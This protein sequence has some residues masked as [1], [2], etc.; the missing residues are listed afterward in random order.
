MGGGLEL[1][2]PV[3]PGRSM[4]T[5]ANHQR[6]SPKSTE[7]GTDFYCPPGT[8]VLAPADGVI[9]GYGESV[10]PA[11]GRWVGIDF[12]NGM[13]FRGMHFQ[14][15]E[16][17]SGRVKRGDLIA[18]SGSSGYGSEFF[19]ASH[20]NDAAMIARTGGPH[21]HATLWPTHTKR[22]GYQADGTPFTVDIMNYIGGPQ[23]GGNTTPT[24]EKDDEIMKLIGNATDGYKFVDELG[25]D[26]WAGFAF[27]QGGYTFGD[28]LAAAKILAEQVD[29]TGAPVELVRHMANA[30][31]DQKRSQI[32]TDVVTSLRPLFAEI[33]QAVAGISPERFAELIED[34]LSTVV[35]PPAEI[36][37]ED[38]AEI[39]RLT[40][41]LE[42][43]RLAGTD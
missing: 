3:G 2:L 43:S 42:A 22:Y 28:N 33:A 9:Y 38:K 14:S 30:R 17:R 34:G 13:S 35:V 18:L 8:P 29:V 41:E 10:I 39:A 19:G 32:V 25:A 5:W 1:L 24:T 4:S 40:V 7:P 11:T 31:W 23:V 6:R 16:R 20:V 12:D 36:S 15:I 27:V 21:L 26:N 37:D